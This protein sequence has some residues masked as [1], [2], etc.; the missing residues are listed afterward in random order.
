MIWIPRFL[1]ILTKHVQVYIRNSYY[2]SYLVR[3]RGCTHPT[4]DPPDTAFHAP[5]IR[6]SR[7]SR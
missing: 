5:G 2:K 7:A 1:Q 3:R 6:P 4:N